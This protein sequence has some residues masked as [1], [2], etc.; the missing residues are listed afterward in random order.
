M[1]EQRAI[2][3]TAK[4]RGA[5]TS[6]TAGR[7]GRILT[8]DDGIVVVVKNCPENFYLLPLRRGPP[9]LDVYRARPHASLGTGKMYLPTYASCISQ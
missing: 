5:I 1:P 3:E 2:L 7:H 6:R 8:V 9:D 4:R